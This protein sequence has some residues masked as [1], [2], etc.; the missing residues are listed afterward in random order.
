[1]S[2][3]LNR[4]IRRSSITSNTHEA[5]EMTADRRRLRKRIRRHAKT[6]PSSSGLVFR[7]PFF[8][9]PD[10]SSAVDIGLSSSR[11]HIPPRGA[12]RNISRASR[13]NAHH[14]KDSHRAQLAS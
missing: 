2:F 14:R 10:P 4:P 5:F 11:G 3:R 6:G 12:F 7:G 9:V 1:M 8:T 13:P